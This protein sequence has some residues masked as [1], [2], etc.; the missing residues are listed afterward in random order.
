MENTERYHFVIGNINAQLKDFFRGTIISKIN[1]L[2]K[3]V[4]LEA[5][6]KKGTHLF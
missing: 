5:K 6:I 3:L 1:N 4:G 2:H